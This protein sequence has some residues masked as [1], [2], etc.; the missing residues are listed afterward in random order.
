MDYLKAFQFLVKQFH[1]NF[2]IFLYSILFNYQKETEGLSV[3]I[4]TFLSRSY[5]HVSVSVWLTAVYCL[6]TMLAALSS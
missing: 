1:L 2:S 6:H 4:N 5:L 3:N